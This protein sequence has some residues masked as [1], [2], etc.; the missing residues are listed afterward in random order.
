MGIKNLKKFIREMFPECINTNYN[1]SN[2]SSK[3]VAIDT[4]SF[5]YKY[6][7]VFGD[8][9]W[10]KS[11]QNF[12]YILKKYNIH[13]N[14]IF[15]GKPPQEKTKEKEKRKESK[16]RL[17][18]NVM[19]ISID[20]DVY[21]SSNKASQL[22]VEVM[23]KINSKNEKNNNK[24]NRLLH[25]EKQTSI[26]NYVINV[27]AIEDYIKKKENQIINVSQEDIIT[28]KE[29]ITLY[30]FN[31]IQAE[32][33]AE[34]L[35]CYMFKEKQVDVVISEDSDVLAYGC[36]DL[37]SDVNISSGYCE[38]I[39][40]D[41]VLENLEYTYEE[42]LDFCIMCGTDYNDNIPG[43]ASKG[44]YKIINKW[45][46]IDRYIEESSKENKNI[47][48]KILNHE[49]SRLL[50]TTFGELD[51]TKKYESKFNENIDFDKLYKF[52]NK[53][54]IYYNKK[55]IEDIWK[56]SEPELIFED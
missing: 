21:K 49:R 28:L 26:D 2:I 46:N 29:L 25:T 35:A 27:E 30:G 41:E 53:K 22:L 15:D 32:G 10:L 36:K 34:A 8:K 40:L 55:Y 18:D 31:Y 51:K 50:F 39:N 7:A 48:Y 42:F 52:L 5:I 3:K 23:K 19:N 47:D 33:E 45:R 38:Y 13:G 24:I 43:I 56:Q 37:I 54:N 44:V 14:F 16:E 11:F 12:I 9:S 1:I 4:S 17:E 6:K 20:L